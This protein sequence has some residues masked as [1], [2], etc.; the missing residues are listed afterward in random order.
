M[1]KQNDSSNV[2][3]YHNSFYHLQLSL[4][5]P[6]YTS[7]LAVDPYHLSS[8]SFHIEQPASADPKTSINSPSQDPTPS[9]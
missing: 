3:S 6:H 4:P 7:S 5:H 1:P 2:S 8:L 9:T